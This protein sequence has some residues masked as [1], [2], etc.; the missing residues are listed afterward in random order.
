MGWRRGLEGGNEACLGSRA[1][2]SIILMGR[3]P[4]AECV[5]AAAPGFLEAERALPGGVQLLPPRAAQSIAVSGEGV[6]EP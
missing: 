5:N 6:V 3:N 1:Y 2:R 4:S